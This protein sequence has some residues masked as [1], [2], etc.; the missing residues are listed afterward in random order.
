MNPL[1]FTPDDFNAYL[2]EMYP[3]GGGNAAFLRQQYREKNNFT[4]MLPDGGVA[5][6]RQP[7]AGGFASKDIGT[8]GREAMRS[9]RPAIW[10]GIMGLL[11]GGG[12]AVQAPLDAYRGLLSPAEMTGAAMGTAGMAMGG[13]M[14]ASGRGLLDYDPNTTN[15]FAGPKAKT[16]DQSALRRARDMDSVGATREEVLGET[17]WFQGADGNWRFEIDDSNIDLV[18]SD[19]SRGVADGLVGEARGLLDEVKARNEGLKV[20]P[21]LFPNEFRKANGEMRARA[22]ELRGEADSNFGPRFNH[23]TNGQRAQYAIS[24]G[25]EDAYPDLMRDTIVRSGSPLGANVRGQFGRNQ[26]DVAR[27]LEP[28]EKRSTMLHELQHGIQDQEGFA[29]GGNVGGDARKVI[30]D[31]NIEITDLNEQLSNIARVID[32]AKKAGDVDRVISAEVQYRKVMAQRMDQ[33]EIVL[34]DPFDIY[35]SIAGEVESRNV[36]SRRNFT[37]EQRV[38]NPPWQTEAKIAAPDDQIFL[39]DKAEGKGLLSQADQRRPLPTPRNDAEAMGS[40]GGVKPSVAETRRLANIERFGYDPNLA[41]TSP[42]VTPSGLLSDYVGEHQAPLRDGNAPAFELNGDIYPDDIYSSK[43][44]QY[45]GTGNAPMDKQSMGLLQSLRGKPDADVTIYRSVPKGVGS[46][47]AGDWVTISK[48]YA[49]DH[50]ES[51]LNGSYDVV[52]K[53]V[54]ASEIFTNGDSI[55][56]FGY[57]PSKAMPKPRND[58]EAMAKQVL[59]MRAAGNAGDVTDDM[60]A[61]ADDPY[62]FNNTPLD[63]SAEGRMGRAGDINT[64]LPLY[65]GGS[66]DFNDFRPSVRG[67][68]GPGVYL[69][70]DARKAN[71]FSGYE[72]GPT[73]RIEKML[74]EDNLRKSEVYPVFA[75]NAPAPMDVRMQARTE[76]SAYDDDIDAYRKVFDEGGYDGVRVEDERTILNPANIRSQYARFDPAFKHLRNL[77]AGVAGVGLLSQADQRQQRRG[78]LE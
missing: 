7:I 53:K 58:A 11:Q 19:Q 1:D 66:R 34:T 41:E 52:E 3:D 56:E 64:S 26:L 5:D 68:I 33:T 14:A 4:N 16:A 35:Q 75:T 72:Y 76:R 60:M 43:A 59:E 69:T 49:V 2:A 63:M 57:D 15:I 18:D 74:N 46:L 55:H 21:D 67:K 27:W 24:G 38:Q 25:L 39:F 50:G 78:L 29:R 48:Q 31:A 20:Q 47:N 42:S 65:H 71:R 61:M 32:M 9:L 22:R 23:E 17:G 73:E 6:G 45:Y 12:E 37:P 13:G 54:K 28:Q 77:S 44:V 51:A 62:M 36:Q 8:T 10:N 70:P 30:S 40:M